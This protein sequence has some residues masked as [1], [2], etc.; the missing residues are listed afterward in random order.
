[1]DRLL[2]GDVGFGKTEVALRA[3]A[4]VALDG[5][6]VAVLCPTTVLASQH[7]KTF[8][9]RFAGTGI[10]VVDL[11][12]GTQQVAQKLRALAAGDGGAGVVVGT[13]R[14]L[15]QDVAFR[16][17]GLLV[18]DEE[19][20]FGVAAKEKL[21]VSRNAV[22]VL[23]LT[24]T[25]IPR[26]LHQA[27]RSMKDTS[28][29]RT[30]PPG[31]QAVETFVLPGFS[32]AATT[33]RVRAAI[34]AE[35]ERGGQ[36][37]FVHNRIVAEKRLRERLEESDAAGLTV[38]AEA[39]EPGAMLK[40]YEAVDPNMGRWPIEVVARW[41]KERLVAGVLAPEQVGVVHGSM[42]VK[43]IQ[44]GVRDFKEGQ[45]RL[46]VSTT[47]VESGLDIG[48]ANTMV[49]NTAGNMGLSALHQLRGRVGRTATQ[50]SVY[51]IDN[52]AETAARLQ[53]G[54]QGEE[55]L[56][57]IQELSH[58]GAGYDIADRDAAMRGTGNIFGSEQSGDVSKAVKNL[59][60]ELFFSIVEKYSKLVEDIQEEE[61]AEA[62]ERYLD[63]FVD[64]FGGKLTGP[65][66]GK[67]DGNWYDGSRNLG[68]G[69]VEHDYGDSW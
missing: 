32:D 48:A 24:A 45:T 51:Y 44:Q 49:V 20:K 40:K 2:V 59:G 60:P 56:R 61:G 42:D 1:M 37:F 7:F 50:A 28:V 6:Q 68:M 9:A 11:T 22:N 4:L 46:L 5:Y 36:V 30:P 31:R 53:S 13:H 52:N 64:K 57:A 69:R 55:R 12:R 3:A 33:A 18:V 54:S 63:E 43:K 58:L 23:T 16:N 62:A 41:I 35:L 8:E 39:Y 14:L 10:G 15:S 25:P 65:A 19:H 17:L 47:I 26:T 38:Q 34:H 29:L 66:A 67:S 27:T 21:K